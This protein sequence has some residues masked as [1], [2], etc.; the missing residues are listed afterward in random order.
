MEIKSL[1][2]EGLKSK[3]CVYGELAVG[4]TD[5]SID[6]FISVFKQTHA[7]KFLKVLTSCAYSSCTLRA[8]AILK[9]LCSNLCAFASIFC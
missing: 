8:P 9:T 3:E 4:C 1:V 2:L 7:H 5:I 6:M